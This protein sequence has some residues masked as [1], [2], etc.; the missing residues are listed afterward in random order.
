MD[1]FAEQVLAIAADLDRLAPDAPI[2]APML[3]RFELCLAVILLIVTETAPRWTPPEFITRSGRLERARS[4]MTPAQLTTIR[5]AKIDAPR[6]AAYCDLAVKL[7][8]ALDA[9][10]APPS[11]VPPAAGN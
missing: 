3:E 11:P 7:S 4:K 10:K 1:D 8:H 5:A 6:H 9:A 2:P